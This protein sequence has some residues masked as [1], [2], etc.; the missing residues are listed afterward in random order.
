MR[1]LLGI[2][3]CAVIFGLV[4]TAKAQTLSSINGTVT[5]ASGASVSAAVVTVTDEHT[6]FTRTAKSAKATFS[7][8]IFRLAS[9]PSR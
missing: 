9:I 5:D 7:F 4:C 3:L 2:I 8:W 1:N 6:S